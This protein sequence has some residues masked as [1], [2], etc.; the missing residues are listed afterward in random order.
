MYSIH[1]KQTTASRIRP[2]SWGD[3]HKKTLQKAYMA[4]FMSGALTMLGITGWLSQKIGLLGFAGFIALAF[5]PLVS[6]IWMRHKTRR[7]VWVLLE[8]RCID[9]EIFR[10]VENNTEYWQV[11]TLCE[12]QCHDSIWRVTPDM[13]YHRFNSAEAAKAFL[14]EHIGDDNELTLY[15]NPQNPL[16]T[17]L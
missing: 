17:M 2:I 6:L 5:M 7:Q 10:V 3:A 4:C 11:R 9:R 14:S 13:E 12:F 8:A 16:H 1:H 15:V